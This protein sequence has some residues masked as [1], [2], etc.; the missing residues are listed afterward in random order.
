LNKRRSADDLAQSDEKF[1]DDYF[2][3]DLAARPS[4]PAVSHIPAS[5]EYLLP[6]ALGFWF[7]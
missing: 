3:D 2:F 5:E 4:G 7:F 6:A 1:C